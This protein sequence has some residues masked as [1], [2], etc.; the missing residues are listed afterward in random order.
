MSGENR[1]ESE[2]V[3]EYLRRH[4]DFLV[5]HPDILTGLVPP[6][7]YDGERVIDM[8]QAIVSR[9]RDEM[10]RL[11]LCTTEM[12]SISRA[13]MATQSRTHAAVLALLAAESLSGLVKTIKHDLPPLL[14]VEAAG[15]AIEG[16]TATDMPEGVLRLPPGTVKALLGDLPLVLRNQVGGEADLFGEVASLIRSDALTRLDDE[17]G[18][19]MGLLGFGARQPDGFHPGQGTELLTFL[20]QVTGYCLR[21]WLKS[22]N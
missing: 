7:R 13:N 1:S 12:A 11:H 18:Q 19:P 10:E 3:A 16:N 14:D 5:H 22:G 4:P 20:V 8:Q 2:Q 21:R 17:H 9:L 6:P 15:L